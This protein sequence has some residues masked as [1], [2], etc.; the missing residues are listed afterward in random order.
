MRGV[1]LRQV[2]KIVPLS[3]FADWPVLLFYTGGV[4]FLHA[5]WIYSAAQGGG[6]YYRRMVGFHFA[7]I[8]IGAVWFCSALVTRL[9]L[10][11]NYQ[12][13]RFLPIT[14]LQKM[15]I[16]LIE[17]VVLLCVWVLIPVIIMLAYTGELT[18][19]WQYYVYSIVAGNVLFGSALIFVNVFYSYLGKGIEVY[20]QAF[21]VF[22]LFTSYVLSCWVEP[23]INNPRHSVMLNHFW[24]M[25]QLFPLI[26][27]LAILSAYVPVLPQRSWKHLFGIKVS[28]QPLLKTAHL[29]LIQPG[30]RP[31]LYFLQINALFFIFAIL[32]YLSPFIVNWIHENFN[33]WYETNSTVASLY[34][35][36]P[37]SLKYLLGASFSSIKFSCFCLF[38]GLSIVQ[39]WRFRTLL[40]DCRQRPISKFYI[41]TMIFLQMVVLMFAVFT[42]DRFG[43]IGRCPLLLKINSSILLL[44][45]AVSVG[46]FAYISSPVAQGPTRLDQS[47]IGWGVLLICAYITWK[48][49]QQLGFMNYKQSVITPNLEL[50]FM[51]NLLAMQIRWKK[52]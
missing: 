19:Q 29:S 9:G 44:L 46:I 50:V 12:P 43:Y 41:L 24:T 7:C 45:M 13:L 16:V 48:L 5:S 42:L 8:G 4:V 27:I 22:V 15:M 10:P 35:H 39:L 14:L 18:N 40:W 38:L 33:H 3:V 34:H 20:F 37:E 1:S 17:H 28:P 36:L 30:Y 25:C 32:A 26:W 31:T 51:I 23:I 2:L 21:L 52:Y 47:G 49:I 6:L 11:A